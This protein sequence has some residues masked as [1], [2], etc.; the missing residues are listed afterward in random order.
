MTFVGSS[1]I[2]SLTVSKSK[3]DAV[4]SHISMDVKSFIGGGKF[5]MR[6][7]GTETKQL[8]TVLLTFTNTV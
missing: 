4:L 2:I 1:I 6:S 5:T 7:K 8:L 3:L